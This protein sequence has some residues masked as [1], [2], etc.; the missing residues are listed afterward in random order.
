MVG[1]FQ[2]SESFYSVKSCFETMEENLI[3]VSIFGFLTVVV[4]LCVDVSNP[5]AFLL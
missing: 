3:V 4:L 2:D 1:R 5:L